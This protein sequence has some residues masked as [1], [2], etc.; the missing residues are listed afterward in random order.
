MSRL[1]L[2]AWNG[3]PIIVEMDDDIAGEYSPLMVRRAEYR[4]SSWPCLPAV[5]SGRPYGECEYYN[6]PD[7]PHAAHTILAENFS[8]DE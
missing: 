7:R 3:L 4:L 8:W 2:T 5:S 6:W 1:K